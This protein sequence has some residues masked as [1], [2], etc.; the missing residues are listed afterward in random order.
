M[1]SE[2]IK[3]LSIILA[4]GWIFG[5]A[6]ADAQTPI[7]DVSPLR[8]S[9]QN[10]SWVNARNHGVSGSE[11]TA[12]G[13]IEAGSKELTVADAG[14]FKVGQ[15]VVVYGANVRIEDARIYDPGQITLHHPIESEIEIRGFDAKDPTSAPQ[16]FA[17]KA[18]RRI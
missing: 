14:D 12:R 7:A 18:K 1:K 5:S 15:G 4:A 9:H 11:F 13:V 3:R 16:E 17:S 2:N 8:P 6:V 10:H